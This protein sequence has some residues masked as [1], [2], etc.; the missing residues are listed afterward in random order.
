MLITKSSRAATPGASL[1]KTPLKTTVTPFHLIP[2][3]NLL[4][5]QQKRN[6]PYIHPYINPQLNQNKA[7]N[8]PLC[9]VELAKGNEKS[10]YYT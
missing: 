5:V 4:S 10:F 3:I 9:P 1:S 7:V 6:P 8:S 2:F